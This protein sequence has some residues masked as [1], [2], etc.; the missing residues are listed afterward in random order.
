MHEL[1]EGYVTFIDPLKYNYDFSNL[2]VEEN[3]FTS[4]L[5]KFSW[6]ATE[7]ALYKIFK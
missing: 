1:F 5:N 2:N 4:V 7:E 3:D 6:M